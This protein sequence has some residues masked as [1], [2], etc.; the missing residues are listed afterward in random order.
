MRKQDT[1]LTCSMAKRIQTQPKSE[2]MC[3]QIFKKVMMEIFF[4]LKKCKGL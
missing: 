1:Y 4:D 2:K 3:F